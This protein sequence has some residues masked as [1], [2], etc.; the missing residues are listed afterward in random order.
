MT[1]TDHPTEPTTHLARMLSPGA[2]VVDVD[3]PSRKR[4]FEDAAALFE[5]QHGAAARDVLRQLFEREK[6][7]STALG[8]GVAIPHARASNRRSRPF[9]GCGRRSPSTRPTTSPCGS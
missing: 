9:C 7:G 8:C 2:V 3:A 6:L 1:T 4:V 5:N